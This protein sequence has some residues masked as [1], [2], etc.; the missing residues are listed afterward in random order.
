MKKHTIIVLSNLILVSVM[1]LAFAYP[2]YGF[3]DVNNTQ[4]GL[5]FHLGNWLSATSDPVEHL[6]NIFT[7]VE[8]QEVP[9]REGLE[10][11][12][13]LI[14][15]N[16][17]YDDDGKLI[18]GDV[19][20]QFNDYSDDDLVELIDNIVDYVDNFLEIDEN[21]AA[22]FPPASQVP[23]MDTAFNTVLEPGQSTQFKGVL[24]LANLA[25]EV[26]W[27]PVT[28]TVTLEAP[29]GEDISDFAVELLYSSIDGNANNFGYQYRIFDADSWNVNRANASVDRSKNALIPLKANK[30]YNTQVYR[31]SN[32]TY[33]PADF[34]HL[35][36]TPLSGA[37]SR[38]V[39]GPSLYL[40]APSGSSAGQVQQLHLDTP[41][42]RE[43]A[44]LMGKANGTR[45][46]MKICFVDRQPVEGLLTTIPLLVNVSRGIRL[47]ANG[48]PMEYSAASV[49][50]TITVR[51]TAG[52]LWA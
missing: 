20:S 25:P 10:Y 14:W 17:E 5:G 34:R 23:E 21:G 46:T 51:A 30:Y 7:D 24:L 31:S 26:Y 35:L 15:E 4:G 12:A 32:G 37:W 40:G 27:A 42:Q 41:A 48:E 43:G 52:D 22:V 50:P 44:I 49:I 11:I 36:K 1:A 28:Y 39:T 38:F 13:D 9:E 29:N 18:D 45:T 33:I 47:D 6:N 19:A 8:N 2:A 3:F 16:I